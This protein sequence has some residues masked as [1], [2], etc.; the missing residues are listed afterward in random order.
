MRKVANQQKLFDEEEAR[1]KEVTELQKEQQETH[2]RKKSEEIAK[3]RH[4]AH[5]LNLHKTE[6]LVNFRQVRRQWVGMNI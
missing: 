4:R 2:I 6:I 1:R 5:T 3:K